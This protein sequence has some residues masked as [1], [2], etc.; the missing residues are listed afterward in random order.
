MLGRLLG[1]VATSLLFSVFEAW[2]IKAHADAELPKQCLPKS[3]SWAGAFSF[4]LLSLHPCFLRSKLVD[5]F[6]LIISF[7]PHNVYFV[8]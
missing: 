6:T 1:G 8:E 5:P 2:L 4:S 7:I 3:F